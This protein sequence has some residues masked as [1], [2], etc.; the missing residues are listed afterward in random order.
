MERKGN[1]KEKEHTAPSQASGAA[2]VGFELEAEEPQLEIPAGLDRRKYPDD[3]EAL[4]HEYRPIAPKNA[5]KADAFTAWKK[6]SAIERAQCWSGLVEY[7][8][9]V[10]E[11]RKRRADT[12][13]KHL[14]TFINKRGWEAFMETAQ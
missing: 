7:A 14:A 2:R 13:V 5:T 1:G 8:V 9:W 6:L 4:W 12:P 11:E 3:F 10:I